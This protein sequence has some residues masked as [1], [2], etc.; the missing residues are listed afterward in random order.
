[1][2]PSCGLVHG[3]LGMACNHGAA[4]MVTCPKGTSMTT[5]ALSFSACGM[6][7]ANSMGSSVLIPTAP[8]DSAK[9]TKSGLC[10]SVS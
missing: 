7:V 4:G 2:S 1:M 8:K 10:K 6:T 9:S 3:K 5:G